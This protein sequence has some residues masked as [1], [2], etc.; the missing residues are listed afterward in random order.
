MKLGRT[1]RIVLIVGAFIVAFFVINQMK[2]EAESEQRSLNVQL[3]L[4]Q[5]ILPKLA[6]EKAELQE[7][8]VL[9]QSELAEAAASLEASRAEFPADIQS[10]EYDEIIFDIAHQRDLDVVSLT[11]SEPSSRKVEVT[12]V[13]SDPQAKSV[14][15]TVNYTVTSFNIAVEGQPVEPAP[16]ETNEFREYI[17]QTVDDI[18]GCFDSIATGDDFTT[19]KVES[20][21]ITIPEPCT[22]Q[23]LAIA[24]PTCI[25]MEQAE[26]EDEEEDEDEETITED[27]TSL[28][29]VPAKAIINLVIYSY[30]G[31]E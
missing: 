6:A 16:E 30:E 31:S 3:Q 18:L 2:T 7:H 9:L 17:Y 27:T 29:A 22:E 19:A 15:Y 14:T 24:I 21:D 8:I 1:A 13:P 23:P 20:V 25:S 11:T 28:E 4:S 10:I 26:T 5:G 12:V